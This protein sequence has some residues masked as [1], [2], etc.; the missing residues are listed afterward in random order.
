[1]RCEFALEIRW[2]LTGKYETI[3]VLD[4]DRSKQVSPYDTRTLR[5][6]TRSMHCNTECDV[7]NGLPQPV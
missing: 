5:K 7:V 4:W 3:L 6:K 1:M 2:L